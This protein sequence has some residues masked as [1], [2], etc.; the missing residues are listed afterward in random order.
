MF[1]TIIWFI[2]FWYYLIITYPSLLKVKK[3]QKA[4]QTEQMNELVFKISSNWAKKLVRLSG[5][6]IRVNG[7]GNLPEK[8]SFVIVSNHQGNF[9]IPIL[10]GFL[11]R[12]LGFISKVEVKKMPIIRDWM[13]YMNCVFID[14]KDRRQGIRAIN[15]G[16]ENIKNGSNIVIFPEGTR[17]KGI[18]KNPFKSGSFKLA[19]KAEASIVP[20]AINGSFKIMEKNGFIIKPADVTVTILPEIQP[21]DYMNKDLK[22]FAS[23]VEQLIFKTLEK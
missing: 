2:Y 19:Q 4:G 8:N 7:K 23:E 1:R 5:S 16:A 18:K 22:E 12:P 21:K 11:E 13:F 3:L 15:Q 17:S 6:T 20:V 14:R 9:D 10:L